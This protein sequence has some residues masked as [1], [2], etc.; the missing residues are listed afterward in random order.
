MLKNIKCSLG[1][2]ELGWHISIEADMSWL[3]K[4]NNPHQSIAE[5]SGYRLLLALEE[6][7]RALVARWAS[8][9]IFDQTKNP[10]SD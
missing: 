7:A 5:G 9:P 2:S 10:S 8:E 4:S 3:A 6:H 1:S